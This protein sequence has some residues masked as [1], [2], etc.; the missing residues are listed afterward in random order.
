MITDSIYISL[1]LLFNTSSRKEAYNLYKDL[2]KLKS[3]EQYPPLQEIFKDVQSTEALITLVE[4]IAN[5]L[6]TKKEEIKYETKHS[7]TNT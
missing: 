7:P 1:S 6:D 4:D 2:L 5:T 3:L